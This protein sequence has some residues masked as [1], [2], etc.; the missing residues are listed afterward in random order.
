MMG[1][2]VTGR[3]AEIV[4]STPTMRYRFAEF[5]LDT[6]RETLEGAQGAIALRRRAFALLVTLLESAPALVA[7]DRILD[8][9][10]GHDALSPNVLP[11][12][13]SEIRQAL[14]DSAQT[15]RLI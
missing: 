1:L 15:P 9:V 3:P 8:S 12:T 2:P 5:T 6:E 14:A 13:V 11:Q 4:R 7:R 10:W